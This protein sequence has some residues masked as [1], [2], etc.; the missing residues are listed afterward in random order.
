MCLP[1]PDD[2]NRPVMVLELPPSSLAC[3]RDT[4]KFLLHNFKGKIGPF[5]AFN[6]YFVA[7]SIASFST[8]F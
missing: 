3:P 7:V 4:C 6:L 8:M 2:G 5:E 1:C